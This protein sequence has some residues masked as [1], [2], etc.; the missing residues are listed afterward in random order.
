M[1][2]IDEKNNDYDENDGNKDAS[3]FISR[4]RSEEQLN[5]KPP[6]LVEYLRPVGILSG[7]GARSPQPNARP[8]SAQGYYDQQRSRDNSQES[9]GHVT[10]IKV[11]ENNEDRDHTRSRR[12]SSRGDKDDSRSRERSDSRKKSRSKSRD[13]HDK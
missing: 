5:N 10:R 7:P 6:V 2:I 4:Y 8:G 3:F 13:H 12:K 9:T 1:D 11:E